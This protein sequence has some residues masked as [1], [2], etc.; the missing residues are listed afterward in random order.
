[1][2]AHK[3]ILVASMANPAHRGELI[4]CFSAEASFASSAVWMRLGGVSAIKVF[5]IDRRSW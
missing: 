3:P 1:M 2:R 4:M 5:R